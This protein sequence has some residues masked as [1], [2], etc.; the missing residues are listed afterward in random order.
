MFNQTNYTFRTFFG[1][2]LDCVSEMAMID[3]YPT[4]HMSFSQLLT[5][6]HFL[7]YTTIVHLHCEPESL[8]VGVLRDDKTS[9]CIHISHIFFR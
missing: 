3:I 7:K 6:F 1:S 4:Q 8:P 5:S 2:D 9:V